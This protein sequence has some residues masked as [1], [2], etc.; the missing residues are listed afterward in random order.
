MFT[1]H[2]ADR[3]RLAR[4]NPEIDL[5]DELEVEKFCYLYNDEL[6]ERGAKVLTRAEHMYNG[7]T[8]LW[9]PENPR[10]IFFWHPWAV[11]M[12]KVAN[13]YTYSAIS[14]AAA[15]GKTRYFAVYAIW[16]FI[17]APM[18]TIVLCTTTGI[19]DA[20][21]RIWGAI[22]KY[23]TSVDD[24]PGKLVQYR[25]EIV[26]VD[27]AG[28]PI[29]DTGIFLVAGEKKAEAEALS[30]IIG[31]HAKRVILIADELPELSHNILLT[32]KGNLSANPYFQIIGLGNFKNRYD[33][34]G[35]LCHPKKGWDS[36]NVDMEEWE[37]EL[38][39]CVHFDGM[40]SPNVTEGKEIYPGIYNLKTY[41]EH[42]KTLGENS[43]EF[44]RMCR[45]WEAPI[46]MDDALYTEALLSA[47]KAYDTAKD[48]DWL[49]IEA[50][51]SAM[52]PAFT[53]EG[54]R[55]IQMFGWVGVLT[56][57][58][59]VFV[60]DKYIQLRE[61]VRMSDKTISRQMAEQFIENCETE[62]VD[63]QYAAL[64]ASA[65]GGIV[66][67]DWISELW[68][69]K[70]FRVNFGGA[71]SESYVGIDQPR[72]CRDAYDRRVSELW[73]QGVEYFR[74][75]Q[76]KGID[77]EIARELKARKKDT[78]K[79]PDGLKLRVES[80][81]DM[82]KRLGF[83]CDLSDC[84]WVGVELARCRMGFVAGTP[85]SVYHK[86]DERWQEQVQVANA[87]YANGDYSDTKV[88][89]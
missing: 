13:S 26:S 55:C 43:A 30:K 83:S 51:W 78:I 70:V 18:D 89:A 81:K 4:F 56:N 65:G 11:K 6:R 50:R 59:R 69:R 77:P 84:L 76:I 71:P 73:G 19:K 48:F 5:D 49:T 87:V 72:R 42:Q 17:V 23:W 74:Y 2:M 10:E 53:S 3:Y 22:K 62:N 7:V 25:H 75:G 60:V 79:G 39:W 52:D 28:N 29:G 46:G 82:K 40:R 15:S 85:G 58:V 9:G 68:S 47:G 67:A 27:K 34:F 41:R 45:S 16:N 35:E 32:A 12:N 88:H 20:A 54:D 57:H 37:T 38:G 61:D 33:P 21:R 31:S 86:A 36:I 14:G 66:L 44:W 63:P 8:I 80:K 64:D 24:L 1:L